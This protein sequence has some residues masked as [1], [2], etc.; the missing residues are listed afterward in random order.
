[1][2]ML[3]SMTADSVRRWRTSRPYVRIIPPDSVPRVNRRH[4][5]VSLLRRRGASPR[6]N[7]LVR[8]L[9]FRVTSWIRTRQFRVCSAVLCF[10][11]LF[12]SRRRVRFYTFA[13]SAGWRPSL[14]WRASSLFGS[15][16]FS[17]TVR[18]SANSSFL[19]FL[20]FR[21]PA[22]HVPPHEQSAVAAPWAVRTRLLGASDNS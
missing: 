21:W 8:A 9:W 2:A 13:V 1:M 5:W 22:E 10:R 19:H 7:G 16:M 4:L 20:L 12:V 17:V 11:S 18:I 6:W 15:F 3:S 14:R